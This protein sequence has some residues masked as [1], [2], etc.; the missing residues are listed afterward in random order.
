MNSLPRP[1]FTLA[2]VWASAI[3]PS[4]GALQTVHSPSAPVWNDAVDWANTG[5]AFDLLPNPF[6]TTSP[7]GVSL[8]I[9]SASGFELERADEGT[10][11]IGNF[12]PGEALL[13]SGFGSPGPILISFNPPIYGAGAAFQTANLGNFAISIEVFDKNGASLG[14]LTDSGISSQDQDGSA[15]FFGFFST[16][17]LVGAIQIDAVPQDPNATA[18]FAINSL[19]IAK[20]AIIPEGST[21]FG[22]VL[23]AL[24][25]GI[26][27]LR[28]ASRR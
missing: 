1:T 25:L 11:W 13:Y 21:T 3:T 23:G 12:S 6:T 17:Q 8:E 18:D 16:T 19:R 15:K 20:P 28:R 22:L 10:G 4:F 2:I 24:G 26:G 5:V 9:G 14:T 7:K 27:C